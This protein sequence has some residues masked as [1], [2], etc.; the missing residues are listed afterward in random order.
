MLNKK[1]S[2]KIAFITLSTTSSYILTTILKQLYMRPRPD[3][4]Y[5]L[6]DYSFPSAH[7]SLSVAI[8]ISAF[9]VLLPYL[10][11][12]F[13]RYFLEFICLFFPLVIGLSRIYMHVHWVSDVIFGWF[14]GLL[15]VLMSYYLVCISYGYS[16]NSSNKAHNS[17]KNKR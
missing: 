2:L 7:S 6:T 17:N 15:C 1:V 9:I 11:K 10:K 12:G 8:F 14:V 13:N 5:G 16:W 4:I 3:N